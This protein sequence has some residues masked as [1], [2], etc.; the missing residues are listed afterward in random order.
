MNERG[1]HPSDRKKV[2]FV[3]NPDFA[4]IMQRYREVHDFWHIL[5]GLPTTVFAEIIVKWF[6]F[7]HTGLPM[8]GLSSLVGPLRLT[9]NEQKQL[10]TDYIP[11][12]VKC[13]Y[14]T[15]FLLNVY[16]EKLL[17]KPLFQ[18]RKDLNFIV[19]PALK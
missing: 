16:Y 15:D 10:I 17:D 1:Y 3:D 4:Y 11:W 2:R 12:A 7:I 19:A 13:A 8:C 6:E 9:L 14:Q 18:V 5:A